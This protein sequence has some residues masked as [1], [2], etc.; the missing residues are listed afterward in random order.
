MEFNVT[1]LL[2]LLIGAKRQGHV[3]KREFSCNIVRVKNGRQIKYIN[4]C[5]IYMDIMKGENCRQFSLLIHW[6]ACQSSSGGR[7]C[8][9]GRGRGGSLV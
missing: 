8:N 7:G 1:K 3:F 9:K 4:G 6:A 2:Y 5:R